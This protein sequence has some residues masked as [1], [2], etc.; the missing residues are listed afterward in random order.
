MKYSPDFKTINKLEIYRQKTFA[1]ILTRTLHGCSLSLVAEFIDNPT[2]QELTYCIPKTSKPLIHVGV[3]LP[4]FFAGLL[5][6]GMRLKTLVS[7]LKTS[8]DDL[9]SLLVATGRR[10]IGDIYVGSDINWPPNLEIPRAS[11]INFYEF[12]KK[13]IGLSPGLFE[14]EAIAGIQEKISASMISLPVNIAKRNKAYILK[15]NPSDKPNLVQN[16][17]ACIKIANLCGIRTNKAKLIYD[18]DKMPGLLIE[19]F[20]RVEGEMIHQEDACQFLD[21]YPADKY[22]VS[23]REISEKIGELATAP[24][25]DNLKLI[26]LYAFS[27]LI[28]NGDLH[29]KN[30]SLQSDNQTGRV[31]ITPA[32]D[33]ICTYVYK[34]RNMALK[35]EGRDNNIKRQNLILFGKRLG[36]PEIAI[37][38]MAD[39]LLKDFKKNFKILH[40]IGGLTQKD[41]Q[42]LSEMILKRCRDLS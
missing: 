28:G 2:Y 36:I 33:L 13:S 6:E 31:Q 10:C 8:S 12:F 23:M 4:P 1:G 18:K 25:I 42:L 38:S 21:R 3:N 27:Y 7:S 9:F 19:R 39:K 22:R 40:G 30:I 5:P 20:D 17:F 24:I 35:L 16:E 14:N 15:L 32:Y 11:Q 26:Q 37:H 41:N 29:A 34:D